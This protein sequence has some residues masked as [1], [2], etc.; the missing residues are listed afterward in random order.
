MKKIEL[1]TRRLLREIFKGVSLTSLA[2]V[3]QACYGPLP[4]DRFCDVNFTGVVVSKSTN[5]PVEG[6]AVVIQNGARN[7]GYTDINGRFSIYAAIPGLS[8]NGVTVKVSFQDIDGSAN[9]HFDDTTVS[10]LCR[11]NEKATVDVELLELPNE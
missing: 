8:A 3:F 11:C 9:G 2:F 10:V 5:L 4:D 7:T 1:K 6:I